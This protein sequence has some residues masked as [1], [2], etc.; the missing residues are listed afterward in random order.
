MRDLRYDGEV[1]LAAPS[2]ARDDAWDDLPRLNRSV[3]PWKV[4]AATWAGDRLLI[5]ET[6]PDGGFEQHVRLYDGAT[7]APGD[8]LWADSEWMRVEAVAASDDR[9]AAAALEVRV[10]D[11]N[12]RDELLVVPERGKQVRRVILAETDV[13]V[14]YADGHVAVPGRAGWEAHADEAS[15]IALH[16]TATGIAT[17]GSDGRVALWTLDGEL[18]A[19][20][21]PARRSP[22]SPSW[23]TTGCSHSTGCPRPASASSSS[24]TKGC[25]WRSRASCPARTRCSTSRRS[26]R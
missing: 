19:E 20:T 3:D 23:A 14:G 4:V 13:I 16:P 15:A 5:A 12:G 10:W 18:L 11:A 24:R 6:A 25:S 9:L 8:V 17:G 21:P 1:L 26:C 2:R 22:T 7:R